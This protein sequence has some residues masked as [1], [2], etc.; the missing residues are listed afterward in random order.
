MKIAMIGT[1]YV[2]LTTGTCLAELGND[3]LCIDIDEKKISNL[4]KGILPIYEPGLKEMVEKNFR[5]ERLRFTTD[6]KSAIEF[7]EVIF[8]AVGTPTG[9][10]EEADLTAVKEVAKN[11]GRYMNRYKVVVTKSTVPVGTANGI[12][13]IIRESQKTPMK[14]SVVSNPE[15]LRE[16]E[17]IYDFM[18][19]DR[20]VVGVEDE[21]AK[22]AMQKIYRGIIRADKPILFT[23][24]RSSELIKYASNA[25]LALRISFMNELS[26]LCD[27][28]GGDIKLI[29]KGM[30][31]DD[32]IGPR[33][34]Q[35]G[36]GWGGSCFPKDVRAL[37]KTM[38]ENN[39]EGKILKAVVEVNDNQRQVIIKKIKTL[40]SEVKGKK[41]A[42]WGLSFKPKTDDMREAPSITIIE[43]LQK[44]GAQITAFDPVAAENAKKILHNVEYYKTPYETVEGCSCLVI[45]TEWNEFRELDMERIKSLMKEPNIV[46]ARNIYD[47]EYIKKSGFNYIGVGR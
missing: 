3:V 16:G 13:K 25:M 39:V 32:R 34:L 35:A 46:D 24:I 19:P 30:G 10:N 36:A 42:V 9:K 4:K 18:N 6:I 28:V 47:P 29:A 5:E 1:G 12:K 45:I 22:T 7:A 41:I 27:K 17:A 8:I 26:L 11:I 44:Q 15:F 2:G 20:I 21:N 14:F 43:S 31:L 23:D 40:L 37:Y 38:E 33:F